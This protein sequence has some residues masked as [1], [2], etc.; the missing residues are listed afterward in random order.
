MEY[1]ITP[2]NLIL[3]LLQVADS[4]TMPIRTL[5]VCGELF[6]FTANTIRVTTTRLIRE[7]SIESDERGYYRLG[8]RKNQL[9]RFINTWR[10]GEKRMVDWNGEWVCAV[11]PPNEDKHHR[12]RSRKA[13]EVMGFR[14]GLAGLW[15]RPEIGRAHV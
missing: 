6:G 3:S 13:L 7:K 5:I 14:E 2:K 4:R 1:Q 9:S 11:L 10:M 8:S 12:A 15:V